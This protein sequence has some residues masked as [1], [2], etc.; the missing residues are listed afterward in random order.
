M[1]W[2]NQLI[3]GHQ[4]IE[5]GEHRKRVLLAGY[6]ILIYLA[7]GSFWLV[8]G[9][10]D[11]FADNTMTL[12][13]FFINVFCFYLV[14]SGWFY[15]GTLLLLA[16]INGVTAY[17]AWLYPTTSSALFFITCGLG[18]LSIFGYEKRWI[19][20]T[21]SALSI[22]LYLVISTDLSK[23]IIGTAHFHHQASLVLT[24]IS[25]ALL[26]YFFNYITYQYNQVIQL[27]N[28]ELAKTNKELDRFVYTASHDLKAPLNSVS[29]L[30]NLIKL[31]DDPKEVKSLFQMIEKSIGSLKKFIGDVTDYSRNLRTDVVRENIN[32]AQLVDDIRGSLEFD[33][34]AK[35]IDWKVQVAK[36]FTIKSDPYRLRIVMNNLLSN[37]IKYSDLSKP[38]PQV[39]ISAA[40]SSNKV[41]ITIADNGIGIASE[42]LPNLFRMFYRATEK[43]TGSG[44]GLY[45]AKESVEKL[46]GKIELQS[47][48]GNGT[49]FKVELPSN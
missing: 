20:I 35:K 39:E 42:K 24:Y 3:I 15:T 29:G 1:K 22:V 38:N 45:I 37:A 27:Q 19:G 25:L 26:I 13:G 5:S 40:S 47:I 30:L 48:F 43:E 31:T 14:R 46:K 9:L 44:L 7:T 2:I 16:R 34:K 32:L 36:E 11:K 4:V 12:I 17:Y 28:E 10:F 21:S 49:T 41:A 18:A 33:E 23:F 6:F 8:L